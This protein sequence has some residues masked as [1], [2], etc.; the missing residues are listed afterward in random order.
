MSVIRQI[1]CIFA[2]ILYQICDQT[3]KSGIDGDIRRYIKWNERL[4]KM[5]NRILRLN[6]LL[7]SKPEFRSVFYFRTRRHKFFGGLSR[8]I[9]PHAKAVEIGGEIAPG[10]MI[11]HLHSVICPKKAGENLRVGPGCVICADSGDAPC[12]GNNVYIASNSTVVGD[13]RI[14]DNVIVGAGSVVTGDLASNAVYVGN[15]A[16]FIKN[17][18]ENDKLLEEI[19]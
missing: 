10:L 16:R 19:M 1:R 15:P 9:L 2:D 13:I 18:G 4:K 6:I 3:E 12:F 8:W 17:I 5:K 14:G 7:L 11:S